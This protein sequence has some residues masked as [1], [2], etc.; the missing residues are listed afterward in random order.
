MDL[1]RKRKGGSRVVFTLLRL[2]SSHTESLQRGEFVCGFPHNVTQ[3]LW[4]LLQGALETPP[5]QPGVT[6]TK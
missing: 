3:T 2:Q 4:R 5:W 1:G 6:N